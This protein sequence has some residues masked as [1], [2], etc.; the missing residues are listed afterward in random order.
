MGEGKRDFTRGGRFI[1]P[2]PD[3]FYDDDGM[4]YWEN[5]NRFVDYVDDALPSGFALVNTSAYRKD[6]VL[7]KHGN[8]VSSGRSHTRVPSHDFVI[9]Y[10]EEGEQPGEDELWEMYQNILQPLAQNFGIRADGRQFV[11]GKPHGTAPHLHLQA[12]RTGY[13]KKGDEED[14]SLRTTSLLDSLLKRNRKVAKN[15]ATGGIVDVHGR[16]LI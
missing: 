4:S 14:L 12:G 10:S 9:R 13:P 15:M 8:E 5:M 1:N 7:D 16:R 6:K 2:A 3:S 11:K